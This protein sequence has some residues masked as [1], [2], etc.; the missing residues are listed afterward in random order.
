MLR[1]YHRWVCLI[2]Q[3]SQ[4]STPFFYEGNDLA[5]C[6]RNSWRYKNKPEQAINSLHLTL[7]KHTHLAVG[8]NTELR[9]LWENIVLWSKQGCFQDRTVWP[10]VRSAHNTQKD[11]LCV[12]SIF[13]HCFVPSLV[14]GGGFPWGFVE[15][16][17]PIRD[18]LEGSL[19]CGHEC[20]DGL[21][22]LRCW[23]DAGVLGHNMAVI[24]C[25]RSERPLCSD[26]GHIW[27]PFR[28]HEFTGKYEQ[29][30]MRR[31]CN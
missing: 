31:W 20:L 14:V 26:K 25:K 22:L 18:F 1:I 13:L 21:Q 27:A 11:V 28:F 8:C 2:I 30:K 5:L 3:S 4:I 19:H 7:R 10:I 24:V 16:I 15:A 23:I 9:E 17:H 6:W 29:N 12:S